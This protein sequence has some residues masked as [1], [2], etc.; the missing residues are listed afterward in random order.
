MEEGFLD[1][2]IHP[3]HY[4]Q[5]CIGS[6]K[7]AG[8]DF[9]WGFSIGSL[10]FQRLAGEVDKVQELKKSIIHD[11]EAQKIDNFIIFFRSESCPL[12]FIYHILCSYLFLGHFTSTT[13]VEREIETIKVEAKAKA[14]KQRDWKGATLGIIHKGKSSLIFEKVLNFLGEFVMIL[15]I[16][17]TESCKDKKYQFTVITDFLSFGIMNTQD[18]S[19]LL[20]CLVDMFW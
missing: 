2:D 10:E 7:M 6:K 1:R 14:S 15:Q 17:V 11:Q 12:L 8:S 9:W 16:S 13:H 20:K 5:F 19:C 18:T 3:G 4:G